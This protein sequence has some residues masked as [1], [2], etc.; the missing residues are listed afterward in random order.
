MVEL[1]ISP[2]D[3]V[4]LGLA[5]REVEGRV[6]E[7]HD[8]EIVLLKLKS[9]YNI[10][11]SKESIARY[12]VIRRFKEKAEDF[13]IPTGK[14]KPSIGLVVTGGTIASK[15]DSQTGGVKPITDIKDFAKVYHTLFDKVNIKKLEVPFIELSENMSS[16]H[17]IKIAEKVKEMLDDKEIQGVIVTHGSDTLHYTSSALSFFLRDLNK[18]VVLT[19][20]QRS[21]DRASSDAEMNLNCAVEMVLSD[22]AEVMIVG[23][24]STNDNF[25]YALPGTKVRKM[26]TSR[27]AT[28]K[29]INDSPI[30]KIQNGKIEFFSEYRPRNKGRTDLDAKFSD[31][32]ALVK[33]YPGQKP[34]I[35]DFYKRNYKGIVV[36]M[37]GLGHVAAGDVKNSWL[38]KI[39]K[40]TKEGFVIC[41]APQTVYG[42]LNPKVYSSGRDLEKAGIIYL[43]D[44]LSET[45]FVKLGWVLGHRN[46]K[47]K[48]KEKMLENFSGEFNELLTN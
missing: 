35:L 3:Y 14:G 2:G 11:I 8:G 4:K 7:S 47:D 48:V 6:L 39:K 15:L 13:K 34:D 20:S 46:W 33:F 9:G 10:G 29:A 22:C 30:A 38:S 1:K 24:A 43:E 19:F 27:R 28:F 44:M 17:W 36:E 37:T 23:H 26:H 21:V 45:A 32:V 40:L 5:N 18:P 31:K 41:A 25:C 42:R 12:K 16:A